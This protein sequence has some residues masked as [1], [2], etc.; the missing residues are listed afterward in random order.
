MS[1]SVYLM[2]ITVN[3]FSIPRDRMGGEEGVCGLTTWVE[4]K[5]GP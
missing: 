5:G 2:K 3:G 1:F 4:V